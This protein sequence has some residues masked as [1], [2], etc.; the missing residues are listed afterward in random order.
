MLKLDL[1]RILKIK[2]VEK[3]NSYLISRGHSSTYAS[4]LVNGQ[5]VS[6]SFD[7]LEQFCVDFNC[8]PNDLFDFVPGKDMVL[9]E[10]HALWR[11]SKNNRVSEVN[12]LLQSLPMDRIEELHAFLEGGK[13]EV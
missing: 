13:R 3:R 1:N 4:H 12:R 11:V 7:K 6:I 8:T 2:G 9:P 10:D 5:I